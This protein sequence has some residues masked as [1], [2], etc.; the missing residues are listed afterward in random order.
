MLHVCL[1]AL[2]QQNSFD[3]L[4]AKVEKQ[5]GD[6]LWEQFSK[7]I[8]YFEMDNL[9]RAREAIKELCDWV[10]AKE[11][12]C[13]PMNEHCDNL[14]AVI[15][16]KCLKRFTKVSFSDGFILLSFNKSDVAFNVNVLNFLGILAVEL[17]MPQQANELFC[18]QQKYFQNRNADKISDP[19]EEVTILNNCGISHILTGRFK[20]AVDLLCKARHIGDSVR[21]S[22][23]VCGPHVTSVFAAV[24]NNLGRVYLDAGQSQQ[25]ED[26]LHKASK[27]LKEAKCMTTQEQIWSVAVEHNFVQLLSA[28]TLRAKMEEKLKDIYLSLCLLD[29]EPKPQ[30]SKLVLVELIK[31]DLEMKQ[32][33]EANKKL[34]I[35]LPVLARYNL[36]TEHMTADEFDVLLL[37]KVAEIF[38]CQG[39]ILKANDVLEKALKMCRFV[40]GAEHPA[41]ADLLY[42]CG[43]VCY[44]LEEYVECAALLS[45]ATKIYEVHYHDNYPRLMSCYC[46]LALIERF[47]LKEAE[48]AR[49]NIERA[50]GILS[51]VHHKGEQL[52]LRYLK[53]LVTAG[54]VETCISFQLV[55]SSV[56]VSLSYDRLFRTATWS[57]SCASS[58]CSSSFEISLEFYANNSADLLLLFTRMSVNLAQLGRTKESIRITE[59]ALHFY[60]RER[61]SISQALLYSCLGLV[62]AFS[63]NKNDEISAEK[64]L[65]IA[66]RK[67]QDPPE[68]YDSD[69]RKMILLSL[70]LMVQAFRALRC[71]EK[72][73]MEV[74]GCMSAVLSLDES[75]GFSDVFSD[76]LIYTSA[77]KLPFQD[78]LVAV[79]VVVNKV[80]CISNSSTSQY[81]STYQP[82]IQVH[83]YSMDGPTAE[84]R[85]LVI[86][87]CQHQIDVEVLRL[88]SKS[89]S[90]SVRQSLNFRGTLDEGLIIDVKPVVSLKSHKALCNELQLVIPLYIAENLVNTG[91]QVACSI[92]P[93]RTDTVVGPL[94]ICSGFGGYSA[95][96]L[97]SSQVLISKFIVSCVK[98]SDQ[99]GVL[100]DLSL[101]SGVLSVFLIEPNASIQ[102]RC[103]GNLV[104]LQTKILSSECSGLAS[105][106]KLCGCSGM[107][108]TVTDIL[109][110]SSR[111]IGIELDL[112]VDNRQCCYQNEKQVDRQLRCLVE[113]E[114]QEPLWEEETE[115]GKCMSKIKVC[116]LYDELLFS[117]M[118][119]ADFLICSCVLMGY[120]PDLDA[121]LVE[122]VSTL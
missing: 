49:K 76:H 45:E 44:L 35:I 86:A 92:S 24:H 100:C 6:S 8:G 2:G 68:S 89:V 119:S 84:P 106:S 108:R 83:R 85:V 60:Q 115:Q 69:N 21:K 29:F 36:W 17:S 109:V 73:I 80:F 120:C 3:C 22:N 99:L 78:K 65:Q 90:E 34:D 58:Q 12:F 16:R 41:T 43:K 20:E 62:Q 87:T 77:H 112:L 114:N 4:L 25:A 42:R 113:C 13:F 50:M 75:E 48:K 1:T 23:H 46:K 103:L 121:F 18:V 96:T 10:T 111:S 66:W 88:F 59:D 38:Q 82:T 93:E 102:L 116:L 40:Y 32:N 52:Q 19:L 54:I 105:V 71:K 7:V 97:C 30:V 74:Y 37:M 27:L 14:T 98:R 94:Q 33:E 72:E 53:Q 15:L 118:T 70:S 117:P 122:L 110:E 11:Y 31:V 51:V 67:L 5:G 9:L 107:Y 104:E 39:Q 26:H 64:S 81:P 56:N 57:K 28:Q 47:H 95:S 63:E 101:R 61:S 55:G 91:N 79:D